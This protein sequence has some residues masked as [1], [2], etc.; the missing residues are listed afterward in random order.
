MRKA[1][2]KTARETLEVMKR[3]LLAEIQ[4]G[5]KQGRESSKDEGMDTYDLAS[6]ERERE[7]NFI[8]TDRDRGKLK[9][10][11]DALDRI[12]EGSYGVCES[13]EQE[14]AEGRLQAMPFTRLCVQC[15]ADREIEAKQSRRGDDDRVYRRLGTAD[16]DDEGQ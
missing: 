4:Q 13:C 11:E 2:L 15:Q 5:I 7:I 16:I 12:G 1:F 9:S 6:E 3:Q 8:L 10:I 14:I